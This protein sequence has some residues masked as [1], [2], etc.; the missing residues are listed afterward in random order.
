MGVWVCSPC[1]GKVLRPSYSDVGIHDFALLDRKYLAGPGAIFL[2]IIFLIFPILSWP[3][4]YL[5]S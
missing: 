5:K 2:H 4:D 3:L 1:R